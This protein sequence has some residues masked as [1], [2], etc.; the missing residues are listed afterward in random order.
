MANIPEPK[1]H[2]LPAKDASDESSDHK[3]SSFIS[4]RSRRT[5]GSKHHRACY[6]VPMCK[7]IQCHIHELK[8]GSVKKPPGGILGSS[9][10]ISRKV[11]QNINLPTVAIHSLNPVSKM[12]IGIYCTIVS[13]ILKINII[14]VTKY[15]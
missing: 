8:P 2:N 10:A 4:S 5:S 12:H 1:R 3:R 7:S 14:K 15:G 13:K 11:I 9:E 6:T